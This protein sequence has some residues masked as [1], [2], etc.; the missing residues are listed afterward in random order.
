MFDIPIEQFLPL[1]SS[2]HP[3]HG[4][5]GAQLTEH[6]KNCIKLSAENVR[7]IVPSSARECSLS[8]VRECIFDS[9]INTSI[10][11]EQKIT[12]KN[13]FDLHLIDYMVDMIKKRQLQLNFQ[14][15]SSTLDAGAKIYAGRVDFVHKETYRVLGGLGRG[16]GGEDSDAEDANAD[17]GAGA[18]RDAEDRPDA[19]R[20]EA[21]ERKKAKKVDD[22]DSLLS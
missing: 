6:Y 2:D 9:S 14:V 3:L 7:L 10:R 5:T 15:A 13:A 4:L 12:P 19:E 8:I 11:D 17:E 22:V 1:F 20:D 18:A 21:A 16:G